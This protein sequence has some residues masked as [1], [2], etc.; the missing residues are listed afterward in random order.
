MPAL[1]IFA[2]SF[3]G[4]IV[5]KTTTHFQVFVKIHVKD[6]NS[7]YTFPLLNKHKLV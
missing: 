6:T 7:N 4:K 5:K 3:F 1:L 2:D